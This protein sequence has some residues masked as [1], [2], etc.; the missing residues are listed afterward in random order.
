[1]PTVSSN[2]TPVI[3]FSYSF[4][5]TPALPRCC[6]VVVPNVAPRHLEPVVLTLLALWILA[7]TAILTLGHASYLLGAFLAGLSFCTIRS[8]H[9]HTW[10]AQ[11][12]YQQSLDAIMSWLRCALLLSGK[13]LRAN[14]TGKESFPPLL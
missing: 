10:K 1:M 9:S 2:P 12:R 4:T 14:A 7:L 11:A 8:L 5:T 6:R 13:K 3:Q